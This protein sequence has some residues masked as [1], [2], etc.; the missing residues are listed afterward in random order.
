MEYPTLVTTAGDHVFARDGLRLPEYVTI[1]EVGHNWFQGI[2]ASNEFEE[3]WLDEGVNEWAD[4]E[5]MARLYGESTS[6]CRLD[7]LAGRGV[8]P[9]PRG[10][11]ATWRACR[12]RSP[13]RP[14]RSSTSRPTRPRPTT[15][16]RWRS[17]TLENTVGPRALRRG[18]EGLRQRLGLQAPD[19][20]RLCST[21]LEH[22]LGEDLRWF[23]RPVFHEPGGV[24]FAVRSATA[25]RR[26]SRAACSARA[27]A[28]RC[29]TGGERQGRRLTCEV[30]VVNIGTVPVP[31][32]IELRFADGIDQ[33]ER[34]DARDGSRW[35]RFTV[36][37][38][39]P[40]VEVEIDPDGAVLLADKLLDDHVRLVPDKS[41][42]W[43]ASARITFWTQG[44]M[45]A[46]AP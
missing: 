42:S 41:A 28:A 19:R 44:L 31:V 45:Q 20:P 5:V 46:V 38:S 40:L 2:L 37:R 30:V 22:E 15:R 24:D 43:R 17:R 11:A 33:R 32:D 6:G 39:S 26:A 35:H 8:P 36:A 3:A 27:R 9:A 12:R 29:V 25:S 16:P 34:W 21:A 7:G 1:H 23:W 10:R 4:G 14:T 18:D 13:P